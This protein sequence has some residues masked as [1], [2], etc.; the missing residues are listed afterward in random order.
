MN[1]TP[2]R[3]ACSS[4]HDHKIDISDRRPF[5]GPREGRFDGPGQRILPQKA[6]EPKLHNKTA[7]TAE[8]DRIC[9]GHSLFFV[10]AIAATDNVS[11]G[12]DTKDCKEHAPN[13]S[14]SVAGPKRFLKRRRPSS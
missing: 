1:S 10:D 4:G 12:W 7:R 8:Q 6:P 9:K 13:A 5:P 14:S 2:V 3:T 11:N